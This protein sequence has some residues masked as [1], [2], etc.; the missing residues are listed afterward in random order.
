MTTTSSPSLQKYV[1]QFIASYLLCSVAVFAITS[2]MNLAV[3]SGMGIITLMVSAAYPLDTF[4]K[5]EQRLMTKGERAR[6]ALWAT[7]SSLALSAIVILAA[8]AYYKTRLTNVLGISGIPN[9][10][11]G[12]L[13]V[14]AVFISWVVIYFGSNT[15][16]KQ[17]LKRFEKAKAK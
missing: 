12:L 3:P 6:F 7:F 13:A 9:W 15:I 11:L 5:S 8:S 2:F 4:V 14:F 17:A 16:G 1:M 10:V